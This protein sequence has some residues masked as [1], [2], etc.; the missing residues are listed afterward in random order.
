MEQILLLGRNG[1]IGK[2]LYDSLVDKYDVID[3][4]DKKEKNRI[5]DISPDYVVNLCAS[6]PNS[7]FNDSFDANVFYPLG[8]LKKLLI[9]RKNNLKWIQIGSYFELQIEFGRNDYYTLHKNIFQ[10]LITDLEISNKLLSTHTI[11]LPHI[12]GPGELESRLFPTMRRLNKNNTSW[13]KFSNGNQFLPVLHVS[14][15]CIAIS[16]FLVSNQKFSSAQP[17][18]HLRVREI[19]N[20]CVINADRIIFDK[21]LNPLDSNYP[22]VK[23][24]ENVIGFKPN[25]EAKALINSTRRVDS[26]EN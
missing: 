15:A 21:D 7:N 3:I 17:V 16:Q 14:D 23:F 26:N 2:H 19:I 5:E 13:E 24:P 18:L 12:T 9:N 10:K 8:I 4:T 22:M 11:I 20:E 6:A 1:F 25:L